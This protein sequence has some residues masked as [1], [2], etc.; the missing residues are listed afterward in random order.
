HAIDGAHGPLTAPPVR[1]HTRRVADEAARTLTGS[2]GLGLAGRNSTIR[3]L[4]G[5]HMQDLRFTERWLVVDI[6]AATPLD[7]WDGVEQVC[8]PARAAT[9]M[10]VAGDWYR[11]EFQLRDGEDETDLIPALGSLLQPWTG[12]PDL[13]GL[14]GVRSAVYTFRARLATRFQV[15]RVFLLGGAAH[16]TPP[17]LRTGP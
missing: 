3:G 9:F 1:V 15:G 10:H 6:R 12:Q 13:A 8:D 14:E 5:V 4:V 16:P 2:P 7:T 11:W 17:S